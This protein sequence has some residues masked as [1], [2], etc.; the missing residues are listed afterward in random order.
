M[1]ESAALLN[2]GEAIGPVAAAVMG[3]LAAVVGVLIMW[4]AAT[5][6]YVK[7]ASFGRSVLASLVMSVLTVGTATIISRVDESVLIAVGAS[8]VVAAVMAIKLVYRTSIWKAAG[9][10]ILNAMMQIIIS[11]LYLRARMG[12]IAPSEPS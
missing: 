2:Q 3:L 11:S 1:E 8:A 6:V 10:L 12:G 9:I 7:D 4:L 5:I